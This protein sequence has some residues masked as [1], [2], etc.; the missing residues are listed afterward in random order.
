MEIILDINVSISRAYDII[1]SAKVQ[2]LVIC[3]TSKTFVIGMNA[4]INKIYSDAIR[5]GAIVKLLIPY[6]DRIETIVK[7]LKMLVPQVDIKI[8]D[9][10]LEAKSQF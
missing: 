10:S 4:G 8:P 6:G 3:A 1:K 9:K 7:V 5:N 2:V